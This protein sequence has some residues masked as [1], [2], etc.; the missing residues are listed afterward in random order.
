MSYL[1]I[2]TAGHID[3]GKTTLVRSLTGIDTDRLK[4]EKLRGITIEL[5]FAHLDLPDAP[6][7]GIVDVPGHEKFVHHMVAGVTGIDLLLL[8][9]AADEG[10][11]PQTREHMDICRLLGVQRGLIALTK[12][13]LVEPDWL[14]MVREDVESFVAG[15]FLEGSPI[16]PVSSETGEGIDDLKDAIR[17]RLGGIPPRPVTTLTRLPVDRVF[18]MKGFGTVVTGTLVAGTLKVGE[19]VSVMPSAREYRIRGLQVHGRSVEKATA[20]QRTAVNLQGA[21]KTSLRRGDTLTRPGSID[22]TFLIDARLQVLPGAPRPLV[23]RARLRLHVGTSE[24]LARVIILGRDA[25]KPGEEGMVQFRLESPGVALPRDRFV[26]RSYS[27]IVT[28]GGGDLIDTHPSKHKKNSPEIIG[29]LETLAGT[30]LHQSSLLLLRESALTGLEAEALAGRL[31]I[32]RGEALAVLEGLVGKGAVRIPL[33]PPLFLH[34]D[35]VES[36]EAASLD[37]L[38]AFH[39]QEPLKAGLSREE[40]KSRTGPAAGRSFPFLLESLKNSGRVKLEKDL[41][42]LSSHKVVLRI[43]QEEV[44]KRVE[45]YYLGVGLQ[46]PVT[47]VISETLNLDLRT[48]RESISILIGEKRLVKISEEMAMHHAKLEPLKEKIV[49]FLDGGGKMTMQ[50]FK[51][52]S[53][54][55]RKYSVPLMEYFDRSGLTIRVGDH[56]VLRKAT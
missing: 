2:G 20:G 52:I 32:S 3:H 18:T 43:D 22:P 17:S 28:F 1:V 44:K 16:V 30:D 21:E 19:T 4:E 56:R 5:G 54:L 26:I 29:Q 10:I 9:I 13:D 33:K 45:E 37:Y 47:G 31:N 48:L 53:G 25:L 23:Q 38:R 50:D 49:A 34:G 15:S 51:E 46:P 55:S 6:P 12:T 24:I 14:E 36:F 11:M 39:R 35:T 41:I 40:L 7:I 42:R 8:V 27:P